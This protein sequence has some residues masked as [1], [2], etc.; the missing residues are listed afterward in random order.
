[1]E[2][3]NVGIRHILSNQALGVVNSVP[4]MLDETDDS[5]TTMLGFD[6]NNCRYQDVRISAKSDGIICQVEMVS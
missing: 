6:D 1:M 4:V 5:Y 2:I 3:A